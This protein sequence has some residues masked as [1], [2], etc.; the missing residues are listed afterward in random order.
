MININKE[1]DEIICWSI[2]DQM[3]KN[4]VFNA[5]EETDRIN[6]DLKFLR[7]L[8]MDKDAFINLSLLDH[9][10]I[11]LFS[12]K[13][14]KKYSKVKIAFVINKPVNVALAIMA[15]QTLSGGKLLAKV[16]SEKENA[17]AWLINMN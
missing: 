10:K 1:T 15:M 2:E 7:I 16:F 9:V 3:T 17:K 14:L 5:I 4:E 13:S 11:S 8:Q 6:E 12:R